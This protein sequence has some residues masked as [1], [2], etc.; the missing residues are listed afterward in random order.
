MQARKFSRFPRRFWHRKSFPVWP[1]P[2][3]H[4][5]LG[6]ASIIALLIEIRSSQQDFQIVWLPQYG[7][8]TYYYS[9]SQQGVASAY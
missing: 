5:E 2:V 7:M 1:I 8:L 4:E 9:K 3:S 6:C